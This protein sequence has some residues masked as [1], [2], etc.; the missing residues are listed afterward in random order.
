MRAIREDA[1][2]VL[3]ERLLDKLTVYLFVHFV[4]E[5]EGMAWAADQGHFEAEE[6]RRHQRVHVQVLEAWRGGV[7]QPFKGGELARRELGDRVEDFFQ[8]I[9]RH[10]EAF[11]QI[12][13]GA[14]SG[15]SA[16]AIRSEIAHLSRSGLPLSPNMKGAIAVV[17]LCDP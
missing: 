7:Q 8:A 14:R 2:R 6:L 12:S 3:C 9:L 10:I 4:C 16:D 15:R 5:E 17:D 1:G 13:Y 11:D